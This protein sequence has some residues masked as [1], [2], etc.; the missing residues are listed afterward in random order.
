MPLWQVS[1][2]AYACERKKVCEQLDIQ[3]V[4]VRVIRQVCK[5]YACEA[6]D[7]EIKTAPMPNHPIPRSLAPPG[8]VTHVAV[9]KIVDSLP[10]YGQEKKLKRIGMDLPRSTPAS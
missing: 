3:P 5:T 4:R 6:C 10:L 9:S 1:R 2:H 7:G 8:T